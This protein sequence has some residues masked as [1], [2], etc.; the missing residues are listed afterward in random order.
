MLT[1]LLHDV[2]RT[3]ENA[4]VIIPM[5]GERTGMSDT[6]QDQIWVQWFSASSLAHE[7]FR[8]DATNA[9]EMALQ[10]AIV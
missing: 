6:L 8:R 3:S 10:V 7:S 2:P 9:H 1:D 4:A 5:Y